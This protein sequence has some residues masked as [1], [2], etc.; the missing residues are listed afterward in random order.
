M[1]NN[2]HILTRLTTRQKNDIGGLL[3]LESRPT[4][5]ETIVFTDVFVCDI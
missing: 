1:R 5:D 3:P 4:C 2:I